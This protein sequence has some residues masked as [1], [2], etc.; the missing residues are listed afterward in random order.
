VI[1]AA[2]LLSLVACS[3]ETP[4]PEEASLPITESDPATFQEEFARIQQRLGSIR[5]RAMGDSALMAEFAALRDVVEK[6]MVE[7]DPEIS[8]HRQHLIALQADYRQAEQSGDVE[9]SKQIQ[10]EGSALQAKIR[11]TEAQVLQ[12]EE[13][14]ER[15]T[16]F[17]EKV[18]ARMTEIDPETPTLLE[19]ATAVAEGRQAS[20]G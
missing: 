6:K 13:I 1:A 3:G 15:M 20:G 7:L 11:Q 14:V 12:Q 5:Q 17:Q 19:R 8:A 9:T 18:V 16:T 2:A 4:P 10:Q